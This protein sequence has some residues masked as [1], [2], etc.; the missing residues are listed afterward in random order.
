MYI[1]S[2]HYS[3]SQDIECNSLCYTVGPYCLSILYTIVC[4]CWPQIPNP[5]LSTPLPLGN[6]KWVLYIWYLWVCF[7]PFFF[8]FRGCT[9]S[10]WSFSGQGSNWNCSHQ[11]MP[12]PQQYGVWAMSVTCATAHSN[13]RS[14]T[15][16]ARPGIEP[17]SSWMP[18]GFVNGWA[19]TRIP[20][21]VF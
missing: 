17:T 12:Q 3:L 9:L 16:W 7:C 14:L 4:I 5:F 15:P 18:V 6:H 8:F 19:M 2:F 13:G 20:V 1:H 21:S 10:I 11:P